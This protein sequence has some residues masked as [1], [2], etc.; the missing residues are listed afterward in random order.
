M[1]TEVQGGYISWLRQS[2][3]MDYASVALELFS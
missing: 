2:W 3:D 1:E